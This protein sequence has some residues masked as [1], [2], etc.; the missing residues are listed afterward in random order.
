MI[1]LI[2]EIVTN[3]PPVVAVYILHP[4]VHMEFSVV[5]RYKWWK[6]LLKAKK[7]FSSLMS[8]KSNALLYCEIT[9]GLLYNKLS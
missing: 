5:L 7:F 6:K 2:L 1:V 3:L 4:M 8:V 9:S